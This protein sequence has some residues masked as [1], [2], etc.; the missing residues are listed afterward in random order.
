MVVTLPFVLLLLDSWPL[1]RFSRF[2]FH[3]SRSEKPSADSTVRLI[4]EKLPFLAL[5]LAASVVTYFV[6]TSGRTLWSPGEL[7]FPSPCGK[8]FVGLMSVTSPKPFGPVD[9][10]IIY[11]HSVS[12]GRRVW[13]WARHFCVALWSGLFL[14]RARQKSVFARRLVLVFGTLIPTIGLVQVGSQS[15]ADRYMYIPSIG[16]FILA[17]WGIGR[18]FELASPLAA[19][20]DVCRRRGAGG[21][22]G[23]H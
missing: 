3:V 12:L 6:Q 5:A 20:H 22:S 16:L 17:V 11:P 9:L 2:T 10:S 4:V 21:L 14:W 19:N 8:R 18:F 7:S 13:R 15:M 23:G 1:E